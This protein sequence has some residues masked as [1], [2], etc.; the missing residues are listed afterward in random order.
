MEHQAFQ[1]LS[2]RV[3]PTAAKLLPSACCPNMDLVVLP[4][5][6]EEGPLTLYRMSGTGE[7]VWE[8]QT[9]A[10][11]DNLVWSPDGWELV[12]PTNLGAAEEARNRSIYCARNVS[13]R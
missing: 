5:A 1:E 2:S 3:L 9:G 13:R 8:A 7:K 6:T 11:L 12:L 10:S 4:D